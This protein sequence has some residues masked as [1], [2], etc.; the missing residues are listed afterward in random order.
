MNKIYVLLALTMLALSSCREDSFS[1]VDETVEEP[2]VEIRY[3]K[4]VYGTVI[5]Q[6]H[7]PVADVL[8]QVQGKQVVT[9]EFGIFKF[10]DLDVGDVYG[11][12]IEVLSDNYFEAGIRIY[13]DNLNT[14]SVEIEL[15]PKTQPSVFDASA[16]GAVSVDG[17]AEI[18]FN[19]GSIKDDNGNAYS[20]QVEVFTYYL[21]P[22]LEGF[23]DRSPGDLS[24]TRADG[25]R[26]VLN[27]FGMLAVEMQTPNG[28][29]LNIAGGQKAVIKVPVPGNLLSDAPPTIPLWHFDKAKKRWIEEGEAQL[30]NGIYVGEVSHFSWWNCDDFSNPIN[31]C[32][33][34]NQPIKSSTFEFVRVEIYSQ[35]FGAV[36]GTTDTDGRIC[37]LVPGGEELIVRLYDICGTIF[38]EERIGPFN[39][40]PQSLD[41][42]VTLPNDTYEYSF[43]GSIFECGTTNP[44][45]DAFVKIDVLGAEFV[46]LSN[47]NG[48]Y[49]MNPILCNDQV[50]YEVTAIDPST[51]IGGS[52]S[53]SATYDIVNELDVELCG[54]AETAYIY[55]EIDGVPTSVGTNPGVRV[56]QGFTILFDDISKTDL[57]IEFGGNTVGSYPVVVVD[58][59]GLGDC[60]GGSTCTGELTQFGPVGTYVK[61][62]F[63]GELSLFGGGTSSFS[64]H[65]SALREL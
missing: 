46:A 57:F 30:E 27:S 1:I 60:M 52:A 53:A 18:E 4:D 16:G 26:V 55:L 42:N 56:N 15:I 10:D 14:Q 62:N 11:T 20:G 17:G 36:S 22:S 5:D 3:V 12:F 21:D 44:V 24:A 61:G 63:S 47:D 23:L 45:S 33:T 32:I 29:A 50:N 13:G 65:F 54:Q 39:S 31:L 38:Y 35:N 6:D 19:P 8:L 7:Q 28:D 9:D 2:G 49:N 34:L 64:G 37:G 41:L 40:S 51:A 25:E 43:Q 48:R 59:L 58:M